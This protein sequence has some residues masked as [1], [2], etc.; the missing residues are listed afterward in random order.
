MRA[1]TLTL[2]LFRRDSG[3]ES[4]LIL[5]RRSAIPNRV[6]H[7][8]RTLTLNAENSAAPIQ[9]LETDSAYKSALTLYRQ[10]TQTSTLLLGVR[11]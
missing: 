10:Q 9:F 4:R 8:C 1:E 6:L 3:A 11:G 5:V 7:Y 2:S